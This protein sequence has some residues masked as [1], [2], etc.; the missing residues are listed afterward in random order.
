MLKLSRMAASV[1]NDKGVDYNFTFNDPDAT[2]IDIKVFG[3]TL[4]SAGPSDEGLRN[5]VPVP[6]PEPEPEPKAPID[7]ATVGPVEIKDPELLTAM[8]KTAEK[9]GA[10]R[11]KQIVK[12]F[13]TPNSKGGVRDVPQ[14]H[15]SELMAGLKEAF[16]SEPDPEPAP[17][18]AP[19]ADTPPRPRRG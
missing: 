17:E 14:G 8:S 18:P 1:L 6:E 13:A 10:D 3:L 12:N 4:F 15:R 19:V 5:P 11:V 16:G 7:V 9:I 2:E